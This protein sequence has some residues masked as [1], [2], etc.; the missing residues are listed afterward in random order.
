MR[1]AVPDPV[2]LLNHHLKHDGNPDR[3]HQTESL[4]AERSC[5]G[6]TGRGP[7]WISTGRL[8]A[9]TNPLEKRSSR[10][11]A[12][13][14][15]NASFIRRSRATKIVA[16][17]GPGTST[18]ERIRALFEAGVDVFR[19]NFSHGTQE[20]H[21]T[22][23]EI[24]RALEKETGRPICAMADLQGPKLRVGPFANGPIRL[25]PGMKFRL[26]LS[27]EPGDE[28]RVSLPHPEIFEALTAG[29]DLLLDD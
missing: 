6:I 5:F 8:P 3:V 2:P 10:E 15:R 20:D 23:L 9:K 27:P 11:R 18:P 28:T 26:D 12:E 4:T 29:T 13:M 7:C 1:M 19:L 17:L 25:A 16:T 21:G 14:N 24:L 22:R